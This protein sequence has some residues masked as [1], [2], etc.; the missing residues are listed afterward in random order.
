M[1][2]TKNGL[3]SFALLG[4]ERIPGNNDHAYFVEQILGKGILHP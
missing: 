2:I 4:T 3:Q 1:D